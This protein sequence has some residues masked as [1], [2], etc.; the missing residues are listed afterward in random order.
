MTSEPPHA[1]PP[2]ANDPR[3]PD[4][5]AYDPARLKAAMRAFKKR[6]KMTRLDDESRIGHGPMT[7]GGGSDVVAIEPPSQYPREVWDELARQGKLR[8]AGHG[9]Y[10]LRDPAGHE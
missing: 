6:L 10:E 2:G 7:S 4:A 1:S 5:P 8:R 9:L 3:G